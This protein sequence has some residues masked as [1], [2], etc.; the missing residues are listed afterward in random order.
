VKSVTLKK[1]EGVIEVE[2]VCEETLWGC[3]NCNKRMHAH[4]TERR[5]W[6]HLD[7]CQYKTILIADVPRV[8]CEEHGTQMVRVPWA[9]KHGRFTALFERL[10]IDLLQDCSVSAACE[11]LRISWDE[12]D[13]IKQRAVDRGL[14]RRNA[15][16]P[17]RLC[18]DEKAVGWGHQY[19]TIVSCADTAPARVLAI[20][21]DRKEASLD[22]FWNS[23]SDEGLAQ[24]QTVA[25]DM[26]EPYRNSTLRHVPAANSKNRY[27]M[28]HRIAKK[29]EVVYCLILVA[30]MDLL[31][32]QAILELLRRR[33]LNSIDVSGH[34]EHH[35]RSVITKRTPEL[36][37]A[38]LFTV[39]GPLLIPD[40]L[41][42]AG[43]Q[44]N[45]RHLE[46]LMMSHARSQQ[47]TRTSL[48]QDREAGALNS[49]GEAH[50]LMR[51]DARRLSRQTLYGCKRSVPVIEC[52]ASLSTHESFAL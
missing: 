43:L 25:M 37:F 19:V 6:R 24:V 31:V 38:A 29:K 2:V 33:L 26:W 52:M 8:K 14:L 13:V 21:D 32:S 35:A 48:R 18:I 30:V 9:E 51:T 44:W 23:L 17:K 39:F 50:S 42:A 10:A 47:E 5:R 15:C 34:F 3:P 28:A 46:N 45:S 4:G 7:S 20:E 22:R 12:A 49:G 40:E 41:R 36:R 16:Q 11:I 27:S 1:D